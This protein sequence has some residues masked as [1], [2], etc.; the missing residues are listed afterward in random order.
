MPRPKKPGGPE[1][2]KRSRNGCWPCK[3]RKIK[4]GEE[5]PKCQNCERQGETCDYSIRLNWEGRTKRK[6][7]DFAPESGFKIT[8]PKSATGSQP[9]TISRTTSESSIHR[10]VFDPVTIKQEGG[11][12]QSALSSPTDTKRPSRDGIGDAY[13]QEIGFSPESRGTPVDQHP[14]SPFR[15]P[16]AGGT[17]SL[18]SSLTRNGNV[19]ASLAELPPRASIPDLSFIGLQS[20]QRRGFRDP[21][22]AAQLSRFRDQNSSSYPSPTD[23]SRDSPPLSNT[24]TYNSAGP[25]PS[26]SNHQMP[27]PLQ[28]PLSSSS[29]STIRRSNDDVHFSGEH[30]SKRLRISPSRETA[31]SFQRSTSISYSNYNGGSTKATTSYSPPQL[32]SI[33]S[34]SPSNSYGGVALTPAA[35]SVTS[36]D[37]Y[38][39]SVT[40]PSPQMLQDSPD[41]R[42]LSVSSLLSGP[43]GQDDPHQDSNGGGATP[44]SPYTES[45]NM[46][47]AIA[48]G[49]DRGF[50]DIDWPNNND[51]IALNGLTPSLSTVGLC[52]PEGENKVEDLFVPEFGF[53]LHAANVAQG[54]GGYY[55]TPVTV[56]IPRSLGTLPSELTEN[57]MN[58]LYFHHFLNHTARILVPHD[59]SENPFKSIL[60]QMAV[61]DNNL[62]HLLLAYSAG[63]RARLL[64]HP[65]PANRIAH[66]VENVFP[67]LRRALDDPTSQISNA[68]LATAIMLASLEIISPNTFEVP[69]SWQNH[70]NIARRMILARGGAGLVHRKDRVSYFLSRWFAY[71]DVLGS[72][73]GGKNDQ[74]LFSGNYWASDDAGD[75]EQA[76]QIDCLMGFTSRCVSILA[77]IA[78][79]ARLCD[80]ERIDSSGNLRE[81][82]CPPSATIARADKLKRDL[83]DSR[84]HRYSGCP[85]RHAGNEIADGWDSLE[86]VATNDAF[87]W[88]GQIHLNR[89]VLGMNSSDPEV[90]LA[91]REIVGA[92]FKV[93]KGGTA[94]ACLL[95]PM[96]TAG[97][98]AQEPAQRDKILERVR[99]VEESGM[100][101]VR[102]CLNFIANFLDPRHFSPVTKGASFQHVLGR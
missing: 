56:A 64:K 62:L 76:F 70:L 68:N 36:E 73:S 38:S 59:C 6:S 22:S 30:R 100:T 93:R 51:A 10:P 99:S 72:L 23:S 81:D 94:E 89:R 14:V 42:R 84:T 4:C 96:F 13:T 54:G 27:P 9:G 43:P 98:D 55:A 11:S 57:P 44:T 75:E 45:L 26:T 92:L 79:L 25:H 39:R 20:A 83:W 87:H 8:T 34:Y 85:H 58:L 41:L 24:K 82:W 1:P 32:A 86:M 12:S 53:G 95:F 78:E 37:I 69:V 77:K 46:S 63:H 66:W 50:P 2:K 91:V 90:Q 5:K 74:P 29:G 88:A 35:S 97:C 71:L 49:T 16:S 47:K 19:T 17:G 31:D 33:R 67:T 48:Y 21:I 61:G 52:Y 7:N 80:S 102:K 101:H 18:D 15:S 60:P 28:N 40:R 65:E 3:T